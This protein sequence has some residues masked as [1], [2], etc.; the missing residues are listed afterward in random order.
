VVYIREHTDN[1]ADRANCM[2]Q[3]LKLRDIAGTYISI[4]Q[5]DAILI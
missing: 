2:T 4:V 1:L 3:L 5:V